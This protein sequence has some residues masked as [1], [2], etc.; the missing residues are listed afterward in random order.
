MPFESKEHL[1]KVCVLH[2]G[3]YH[4]QSSLVFRQQVGRQKILVLSEVSIPLI[5]SHHTF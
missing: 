1:G 2:H 3:I 4:L 5:E